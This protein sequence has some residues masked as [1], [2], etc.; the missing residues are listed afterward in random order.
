MQSKFNW[1]NSFPLSPKG[2]SGP[3]TLL[4]LRDI[5]FPYRSPK[6][7]ILHGLEESEKTAFGKENGQ[8]RS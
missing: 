5:I 4:T 3:G 1:P 2:P 6:Q 7:H 8:R